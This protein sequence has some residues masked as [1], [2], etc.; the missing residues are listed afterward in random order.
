MAAGDQQQQIGKGDVVGQPRGQRMA[1]QVIDRDERLV[2]RPAAMA[3]PVI[4]PTMTPPIRPGPAGRRHG[5]D[6]PQVRFPASRIAWPTSLS[7]RSRWAR[8]AISGTTPP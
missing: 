7:S 8:A 1:L 3:L 5:V 2:V 4:T 6:G